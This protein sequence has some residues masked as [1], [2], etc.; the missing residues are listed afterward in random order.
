MFFEHVGPCVGAETGMVPKGRCRNRVG[1]VGCRNRVCPWDLPWT[2]IPPV[3]MDI[4]KV[5]WPT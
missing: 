5:S 3:K 1:H 2:W 4:M